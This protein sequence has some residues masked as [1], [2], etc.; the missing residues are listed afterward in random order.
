MTPKDEAIMIAA[1]DTPTTAS[2]TPRVFELIS[3]HKAQDAA[4]NFKHFRAQSDLQ[5][6]EMMNLALELQTELT[7][8][9]AALAEARERAK[10]LEGFAFIPIPVYAALLAFDGVDADQIRDEMK[11]HMPNEWRGK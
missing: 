4:N 1:T 2:G 5:Y 9:N 8:A 3:K 6:N 7:T 10:A 11:E